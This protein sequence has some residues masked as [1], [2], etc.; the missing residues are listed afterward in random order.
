MPSFEDE[1]LFCGTCIS[2]VLYMGNESEEQCCKVMN[3]ILESVCR[4]AVL[5]ST[6]STAHGVCMETIQ[7]L[8]NGQYCCFFVLKTFDC[9]SE[10]L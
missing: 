3:L 7:E 5:S 6:H 9:R 2:H 4:T 8:R 10:I 1:K